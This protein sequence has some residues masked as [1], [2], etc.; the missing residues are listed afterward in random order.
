MLSFVRS[1]PAIAA[2]SAASSFARLSWLNAMSGFAPEAA[3]LDAAGAEALV[4]GAGA[5]AAALVLA[6]GA[7][8]LVVAAGAAA[9]DG[10]AVL[11]LEDEQPATR[12]IPTATSAVM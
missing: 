7:G 11:F 2:F 9:L 1:L 6:T 5:E 12:T 4:A 8:A 10:D 3:E